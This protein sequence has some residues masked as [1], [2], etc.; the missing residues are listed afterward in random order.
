MGLPGHLGKGASLARYNA[1]HCLGVLCIWYFIAEKGV[2]YLGNISMEA[3]M[4]V[5]A[6]WLSMTFYGR[7]LGYKGRALHTLRLVCLL[8]RKWGGTM[9][10]SYSLRFLRVSSNIST[11]V[12]CVWEAFWALGGVYPCTHTQLAFG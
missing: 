8:T 3:K 6:F 11:W 1:A 2:L 7:H 4:D 9:R 5:C 10:F 12:A